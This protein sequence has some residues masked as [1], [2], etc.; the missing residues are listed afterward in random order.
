MSVPTIDQRQYEMP[1]GRS[2]ISR[3]DVRRAR[4]VG[5][6]MLRT[7]RASVTGLMVPV[8]IGLTFCVALAGAAI[9]VRIF[10]AGAGAADGRLP[11]SFGAL[12][13]ESSHQIAVP[14]TDNKDNFG[15]PI[16]GAP[17]KVMLEVTVKLANTDKAPVD[18]TPDRFSLRLGPGEAPIS[19]E[20]A[21]FESVR[22]LPGAVFDARVQF[23]VK[24]G[25]Y[26][27]TLLFDDPGG[28]QPITLELGRTRFQG[29]AGNQHQHH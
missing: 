4:A 5:E 6:K 9:A 24:G 22:L 10:S 17:D 27:P 1:H 18:V 26:Q 21:R 12:W 20:G 8:L 13:V 3:R 25:D 23:P 2:E 15:M 14:K 16:M 28:S 29:P 7:K 11:T 19:V